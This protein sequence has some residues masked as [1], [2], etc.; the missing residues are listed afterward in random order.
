MAAFPKGKPMARAALPWEERRLLRRAAPRPLW[1]S[2]SLG[3]KGEEAQGRGTHGRVA[4]RRRVPAEVLESCRTRSAEPDARGRNVSRARTVFLQT[5]RG[6]RELSCG[7]C[8]RSVLSPGKPLTRAGARGIR[9]WLGQVKSTWATTSAL[10]PH[11][12]PGQTRTPARCPG[13]LTCTK[14]GREGPEPTPQSRGALG[15]LLHARQRT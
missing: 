1:D 8:A 2:P 9:R 14:G 11:S 10:R 13:T 12:G 5:R 6:G 15:D 7:R 4:W 3:K